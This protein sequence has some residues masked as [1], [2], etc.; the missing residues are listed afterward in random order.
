M[1]RRGAVA[2]LAAAASGGCLGAVSTS[3]RHPVPIGVY[4]PASQP[5]E[6]SI[7]VGDG[8]ATLVDTELTVPPRATVDLSE[9]VLTQQTVGVA[10]TRDGTTTAYGWE[11]DNNLIVNL[12]SDTK[13]QTVS[14]S[15]V[16][17]GLR[18]DGRVDVRLDGSDG[19]TGTV[20]VARDDEINFETEWTFSNS[21][22]VTYH[23]RLDGT[24]ERVVTAQRGATETSKRVSLSEIVQV[25]ADINRTVQI[26][27]YDADRETP[28]PR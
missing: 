8:D 25:V 23:D 14:R 24:G 3:A 16:P 17:R 28:T 27:V 19:Q 22:R 6:A 2:T 7:V 15:D 26:D 11:V 13:I 4:N 1:T 18:K 12:K 9:R 20:R 21:R 10:V 5:R